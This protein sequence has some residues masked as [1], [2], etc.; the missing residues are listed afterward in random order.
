MDDTEA[1]ELLVSELAR[2]RGRTYA[3]LQ[4]LLDTQDTFERMAP[5]GAKYQLEVHAVWDD[6]PGGNLCVMAH[7]DNGGWRAVVPL[8]DD[9]IVAPDGGFIGE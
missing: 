5:S 8:T 1:R 9:F 7:I 6:R 2:Y 3:D 4:R